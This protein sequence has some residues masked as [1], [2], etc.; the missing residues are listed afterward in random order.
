MKL[1]SLLLSSLLMSGIALTPVQA[2]ELTPAQKL[3]RKQKLTYI[4]AQA[5]SWLS[6]GVGVA[7]TAATV[8]SPLG[9]CLFIF[10]PKNQQGETLPREFS[11]PA[12]LIATPAA[13]GLWY[14]WWLTLGKARKK[15]AQ[16]IKP[17]LLPTEET[18]A[19]VVETV[20]EPAEL[21][22]QA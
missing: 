2:K 1:K 14:A 20:Y 5:W 19:M 7:A 10:N 3:E 17:D 11:G 8:I 15:L 18:K 21:A 16:S 6:L 22:E 12:A 4:Q 9:A 13:V